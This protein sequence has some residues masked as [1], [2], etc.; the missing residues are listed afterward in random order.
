MRLL[1]F[2]VLMKMYS[3]DSAIRP[4]PYLVR[5][6]FHCS[7][8]SARQLIADAIANKQLFTYNEKTNLLVARTFKRFATVRVHKGKK[9]YS[10]YCIKI[11]VPR[12]L[13]VAEMARYIRRQLALC[14]VNAKQKADKFNTSKQT[15]PCL[16][17]AK[18]LTQQKLAKVMGYKSCSSVSRNMRKLHQ[19]DVID[20]KHSEFMAIYDKRHDKCLVNESVWLA[21]RNR[22]TFE[23][24]GV[25]YIRNANEYA[26]RDERTSQ[27]F[28]NVIFNHVG[29]RTEFFVATKQHWD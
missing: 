4:T 25:L 13:S 28:Q 24:N 23:W 3:G 12:T 2:A 1:A 20:Y 6:A 26:I 29:R 10:K 8:R 5:T 14:A 19:A 21:V 18:A 7:D 22:K 16:A 11:E 17:A 15:Q 9:Y 27:R